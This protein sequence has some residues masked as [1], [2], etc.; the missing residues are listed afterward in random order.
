[1]NN[2]DTAQLIVAL[3]IVADLIESPDMTYEQ[4]RA[5]EI[6]NDALASAPHAAHMIANDLEDQVWESFCNRLEV[7]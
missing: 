1:M 4:R 3:R 6:A 5:V 2:A 7:A